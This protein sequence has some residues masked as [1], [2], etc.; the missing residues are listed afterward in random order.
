M[1]D[2]K[3]ARMIRTILTIVIVA[4]ILALLG[5]IIYTAFF[6]KETTQVNTT[7]VALL[8]SS[9]NH[10]VQMTVRGK[11]VANED[12]RS[13]QIIITPNKRTFT[14]YQGYLNQTINTV[15]LDNNIPA[16]EQFVY[17]L[18]KANLIKGTPLTGNGNDTRGICATGNMYDFQIIE[19]DK[20]IAQLWTT[21][22]SNARGSLNAD[23]DD[24]ADLFINQIPD[25]KKAISKL[26]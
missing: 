13:Y 23:V 15:S 8:N 11:I 4:F 10:S 1:A 24:I 25:A 18:N 19:S 3:T 9:A 7:E 22:C 16:Y 14:T 21:S 20:T 2:Y 5:S 12:Y 26:W 17:A 6:N